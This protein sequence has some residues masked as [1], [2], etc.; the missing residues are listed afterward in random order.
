MWINTETLG[1]YDVK[2][3]RYTS[4]PTAPQFQENFP[5]SQWHAAI[6]QSNKSDSALSFY[7]H[8]PYCHNPCFYCGCHRVISRD[9][10]QAERYTQLLHTELDLLLPLFPQKRRLVQIHFGG[11][12]PNFLSNEQLASLL[13]RLHEHFTVPTQDNDIS[14]EIDPRHCNSIRLAALRTMGFNR[15]SFGI[16][17]FNPEVQS[18]INR[19]QPQQETLALIEAAHALKFDSINVDLIY[20]LPKQTLAG[21]HETLGAIIKAKPHRLAIYSYAHLPH[22][23]KAQ[24]HINDSDLPS[25][26]TK[27]ALLAMAINTLSAA[28]YVYIGMDHFALPEDSLTKALE[29]KELHRNFMGYTTHADTDLIGVGCSSISTIQNI[30]SQNY[31]HISDYESALSNMSHPINKGLRLTLDDTIRADIIQNIMC[32]RELDIKYLEKKYG[33]I[34]AAYC[35]ASLKKLARYC[36]DDLISVDEN[37]LRCLPKGI[38]FLRLIAMCFDAYIVD[39]AKRITFSKAI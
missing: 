23:F 35:A 38:P 31:R 6:A 15:V 21:F 7:F 4:Y 20:G 10:A 24:K 34:F 16:Q 13:N 12:T 27:L 11:G 32:H 26:E 30:Y 29:R 9:P 36:E 8:V 2:S 18:A 17:D 25:N 14:I 22:L 33:I 37:F 28:G 39:D 19:I 3:P 5:L 1:R